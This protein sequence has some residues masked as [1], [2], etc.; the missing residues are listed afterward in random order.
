MKTLT[1]CIKGVAIISIVLCF[2]AACASHSLESCAD[3]ESNGKGCYGQGASDNPLF[4]SVGPME[5]KSVS[6]A[7]AILM[8]RRNLEE[9]GIHNSICYV[10][11][12]KECGTNVVINVLIN[13]GTLENALNLF[14]SGW[15]GRWELHD[16][17]G[18]IILKH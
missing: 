11:T 9:N 12:G 6:I 16:K 5:F 2:A 7:S 14:C 8:L 15:G 10:Q 1:T 17:D 3:A 13:K 4:C 18:A